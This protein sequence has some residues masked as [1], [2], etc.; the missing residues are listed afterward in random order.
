M[1]GRQSEQAPDLLDLATR[2]A[3][4]GGAGEQIEVFVSRGCQT[5]VKAFGGEVE[6]LTSAE[7][8]GIGIRVIRDHRQGFACA[9]S[10]DEDAVSEALTEARDNASFAQPDDFA[11]LADPDGHEVVDQDLWNAAAVEFPVERKID[12]AIELERLVRDSDSRIKGV[13]TAL[14]ADGAG[15]A[16]VAT[17][18]GIAVAGRST[19]CHLSVSALAEASGETTVGVGVD[20]GRDPNALDLARVA[21]DAV[22]RATRLLGAH[23]PPSRRLAVVFE[24]RLAAALLGIVGGML[25]GERVLKGRSPFADRQGE[26]IA[27]AALSMIDDPTDAA[28]LGADSHDGEGLACRANPLI[29][30]GVLQGFLHN[31][32]TGRRSGFGSTGSAVRGYRSTPGVGCQAL[33]VR[34]GDLDHDEVLAAVGDGFVV[35]TLSGLHSGVNAVS[36]DFSVGAEGVMLRGGA[37]AE[38]VHEVTLASTL[39]RMLLDIS[40]IGSDLTWLPGGTGA[41]TLVV[42]D[43]SLGGS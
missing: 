27:S 2:L 28:S 34:P 39:P 11:G 24:P 1:T 17:S 12:L 21:D 18:T 33:A 38:P 36:G 41:A 25:T 4:G 9:G 32:Y 22:R 7:S 23:K 26:A 40:H 10:L 6:S 14:F 20:A 5:S 13:R 37:L 30:E 35:Q 16:A 29:D 8:A 31:A 19:S 43:M 42:D 3:Q 15:E